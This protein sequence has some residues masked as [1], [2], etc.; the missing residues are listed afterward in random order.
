MRVCVRVCACVCVRACVCVCVYVCACVCVCVLWC[1]DVI[2][3]MIFISSF[4][5][6]IVLSLIEPS[7]L[8]SDFLSLSCKAKVTV[9]F[10]QLYSTYVYVR[11]CVCARTLARVRVVC[12]S[13][14]VCACRYA[15]M[16]M[17]VHQCITG[18]W[19]F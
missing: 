16:S 6:D 19:K 17:Y 8:V 15:H 14:S 11:V 18:A 12:V 5:F 13:V 4:L 10:S 2:C 7:V 3:D 1:S 9:W